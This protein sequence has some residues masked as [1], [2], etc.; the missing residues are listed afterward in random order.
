MLRARRFATWEK[1]FATFQKLFATF[2]TSATR[3][4]ADTPPH[5][6][7]A[8]Q[9]PSD[10]DARI[11]RPGASSYV[12][13]VVSRIAS[14][15]LRSI[16][17]LCLVQ[18][19]ARIPAL[20]QLGASGLRIRWPGEEETHGSFSLPPCHGKP[21]H[22]NPTKRHPSSP[23][24]VL[25]SRISKEAPR[26]RCDHASTTHDG[27]VHSHTR[28]RGG[29][30]RKPIRSSRKGISPRGRGGAVLSVVA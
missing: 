24:T 25:P 29:M 12:S 26:V 3:S 11:G 15:V 17:Y 19:A 28:A 21:C 13:D 6:N 8:V 22:G 9:D 7:R 5:L 14:M 10:T 1:L 2:T 4:T 16:L 27:L 30:G 23:P 20:C 18:A